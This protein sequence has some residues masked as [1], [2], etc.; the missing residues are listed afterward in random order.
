MQ[1]P[2]LSALCCLKLKTCRLAAGALSSLTQLQ[3]LEMVRC[4]LLPVAPASRF[5]YTPTPDAV[6]AFLQSLASLRRLQHLQLEC[7]QLHPALLWRP[8]V[9]ALTASS[10]L[11]ALI[12]KEENTSPLPCGV[13]RRM[14]PAGKQLP[15][16]HTL[17]FG[18]SS[19]THSTH[20]MRVSFINA[21]ELSSLV[22]CCPNIHQLDIYGPVCQCGA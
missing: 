13:T 11:T 21:H 16:L 4:H 7:L 18:V 14:F 12:V 19:T 6:T 20:R 5:V 2:Q 1:P 17:V 8:A 15:H 22:G 9:T 10:H 3:H